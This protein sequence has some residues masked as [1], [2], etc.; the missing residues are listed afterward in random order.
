MTHPKD[1]PVPTDELQL[2]RLPGD[3]GSDLDSMFD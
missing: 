3:S 2:G 1:S